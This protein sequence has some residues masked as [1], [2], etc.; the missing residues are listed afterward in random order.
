MSRRADIVDSLVTA[1]RA[2]DGSAPYETA[3]RRVEAFP[4]AV[5]E[6]PSAMIVAVDE[7]RFDASYRDARGTLRV[8]L[9]AFAGE[10]ESAP[11]AQEVEKLAADIERAVGADPT[12]GLPAY[13]TRAVISRVT[14]EYGLDEHGLAAVSAEVE[15]AYRLTRGIP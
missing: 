12:L 3:L 2:I 1:L 8:E 7:E 9:I 5:S 13:G 6:Y 15:V 4:F 10:V 14:T 11:R